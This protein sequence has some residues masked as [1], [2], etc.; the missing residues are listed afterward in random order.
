MVYDPSVQNVHQVH[1]MHV[2]YPVP[3]CDDGPHGEHE[4][5]PIELAKVSAWHTVQISAPT[6]EYEPALHGG[7]DPA[8]LNEYEPATHFRQALE[9]EGEY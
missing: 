6:V 1:A 2:G 3:E 9:P 5:A 7:H 8:S 4:V